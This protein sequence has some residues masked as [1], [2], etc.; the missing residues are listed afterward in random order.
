MSLAAAG[1]TFL[2]VHWTMGPLLV[3]LV[4]LLLSCLSLLVSLRRAMRRIEE[5]TLVDTL[6][7]L[8]NRRLLE[9]EVPRELARARRAGRWFFVVLLDVDRL[10]IFNRTTGRPAGHAVLAGIG[11]VLRSSLRRAGDHTYRSHGDRF[12]FAFGSER[13][14]DGAEMAERVR[15]RVAEQA[16]FHP[17]NVPYGCVTVSLGLVVVPPGV[18]TTLA[19]V[20]ARGA[21]ALAL[22]RKE[23]RNRTAG[24]EIDGDRVRTVDG[25]ALSPSAPGAAPG[26]PAPGAPPR[27]RAAVSEPASSV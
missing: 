10:E 15:A 13:V 25:I 22:A 17:G 23:G 1:A 6:T 11:A 19:A 26:E 24:L 16:T 8:G 12:L 14:H 4:A 3:S 7:G 27:A 21:E 9:A 5:L 18:A 20:E 2:S